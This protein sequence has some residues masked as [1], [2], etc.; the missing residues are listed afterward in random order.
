F[1]LEDEKGLPLK[2]TFH[3]LLGQPLFYLS[4]FYSSPIS[5]NASGYTIVSNTSPV[6]ASVISS[7]T[8]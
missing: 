7:V 8:S 3:G 2:I 4:L 6:S 1:S 5:S